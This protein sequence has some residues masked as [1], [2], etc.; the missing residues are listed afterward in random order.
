MNLYEKKISSLITITF[1]F[2]I[3]LRLF[4]WF[5]PTHQTAIEPVYLWPIVVT[6][7][8]LIIFNAIKTRNQVVLISSGIAI[9]LYLSTVINGDYYLKYNLRFVIGVWI[10]F[11]VSFGI[12]WLCDKKYRDACFNA[13][14]IAYLSMV[15]LFGLVGIIAAINH[16]PFQSPWEGGILGMR[17]GRLFGFSYHPNAVASMTIPALCI[18]LYASYKYKAKTVKALM[19]LCVI[20]HVIVVYLTLSRTCLF[21]VCLTLGWFALISVVRCLKN[22]KDFIRIVAGIISA[23]VIGGSVFMLA[24]P[25]SAFIQTANKAKVIEETF[26]VK[27]AIAETTAPEIPMSIFSRDSSKE[28]LM[29]F[30]GRTNIWLAGIDYIKQRPITLLI[31]ESDNIVA[32]LPYKL[33]GNPANHFHNV[34]VE[35]LMLGGLPALAL[36]TLLMWYVAKAC[37]RLVFTRGM[38]TSYRMLAAIPPILFFNGL[39]EIHPGLSGNIMDMFF[40]CICAYL[41]IVEKSM[42]AKQE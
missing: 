25:T 26:L 23:I 5:S 1:I 27:T 40:L 16:V 17:D 18:A 35:M 39:L 4:F 24:T 28:Q 8:A 38:D 13:I 12:L 9:W 29:S 20:V 3:L 7:S 2:L 15:T 21:I 42:F 31:G 14:A 32:R 19:F 34:P 22:K 11:I 33:I 10:V 36:Y 37:W 6:L 30:N 41:I